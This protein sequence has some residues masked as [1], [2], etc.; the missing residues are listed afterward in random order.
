MIKT[1]KIDTLEL[2]L[3]GG[4]IRMNKKATTFLLTISLFLGGCST[5][6][7]A[8]VM[9]AIAVI[10]PTQKNQAQ[11]VVLFEQLKKGVSLQV[12]ITGLTPGLHGFHIHEYGDISMPNG[13]GAGGHFNPEGHNHSSPKNSSRHIGDL[14]NIEADDTG[15][16]SV[17]FIDQTLSLNG[18]NSIIGRAII[19]HQNAD[20][21]TSQ[22]TGAAGSR[23]GQG[24]IGI[25]KP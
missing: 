13:K 15:F 6:E 8:Q 20:D 21:L 7:P 16:A 11:G 10:T 23:V 25:S 9:Q 17:V 24:V 2:H 4:I 22:P 3:L 5:Q 14:G 18:A 12:N 19:V 1:K